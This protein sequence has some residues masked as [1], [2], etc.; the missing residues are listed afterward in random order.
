MPAPPQPEQKR[1]AHSKKPASTEELQEN[2]T[3][4]RGTVF[5]ILASAILTMLPMP[6]KLLTIVVGVAAIISGIRTLIKSFRI[7][8]MGPVNFTI[9]L[10]LMGCALFTLSV[11]LQGIFF[12]PTMEYQQC[13]NDSVTSRSLDQ[14]SRDFNNSLVNSVLG[15]TN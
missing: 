14:C 11:S 7:P 5:L 10:A 15:K 4:L 1:P 3:R 2:A 13:L 8:G 9:I 12:Q 6:W